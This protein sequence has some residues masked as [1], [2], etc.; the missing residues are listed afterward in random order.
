M[1]A[2]AGKTLNAVETLLFHFVIPGRT[3]D[4]SRVERR[5]RTGPW[6]R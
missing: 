3:G 4:A 1:S 5:Y 2:R 6:A